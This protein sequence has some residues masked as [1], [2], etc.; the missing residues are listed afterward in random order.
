MSNI[1]DRNQH[2][3]DDKKQNLIGTTFRETGTET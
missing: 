1:P 3:N 2:Y